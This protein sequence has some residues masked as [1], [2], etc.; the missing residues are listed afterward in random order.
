MAK[1]GDDFAIHEFVL[2][3]ILEPVGPS[4]QSNQRTRS[5][6]LSSCRRSSK[7]ARHVDDK[8]SLTNHF[9]VTS[10]STAPTTTGNVAAVAAAPH[11]IRLR[12]FV[13]RMNNRTSRD[14][15]SLIVFFFF[16]VGAG[17]RRKEWPL[18]R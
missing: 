6:A 18:H 7:E 1:P 2:T 14:L 12:S 3:L 13:P 15:F 8:Y 9:Q 17:K 4:R 11:A 16:W 5:F 10:T